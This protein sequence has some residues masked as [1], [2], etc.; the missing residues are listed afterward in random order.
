MYKLEMMGNPVDK[1]HKFRDYVTLMSPTLV[2]M[3]GKE[4]TQTQRQF[5]INREAAKARARARQ[6][7]VEEADMEGGGGMGV[8]GQLLME[9]QGDYD[10][11]E[12][13]RRNRYIFRVSQALN[14]KPS[15]PHHYTLHTT[16][17][18]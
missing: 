13:R 10:P 7:R 15:T 8:E 1:Q 11:V 17:Y 6:P 12:D 5:L 3:D 4:I 14:P 2:I 9:T 18:P 16:H